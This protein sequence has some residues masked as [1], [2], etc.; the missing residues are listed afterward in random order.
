MDEKDVAYLRFHSKF[1]SYF[2]FHPWEVPEHVGDHVVVAVRILH[3]ALVKKQGCQ[4]VLKINSII[5][6]R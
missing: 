1:P 5:S 3:R 6:S 2:E 4:G